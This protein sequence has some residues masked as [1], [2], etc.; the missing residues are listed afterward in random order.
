MAPGPRDV[1]GAR[2]GESFSTSCEIVCDVGDVTQE[3]RVYIA[4]LEYLARSSM[5]PEKALT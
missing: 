4:I 3:L 2:E 5:T 1:Y